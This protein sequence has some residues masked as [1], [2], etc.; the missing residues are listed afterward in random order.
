LNTS[1]YHIYDASAGSGKTFTLVKAYLKILFGSTNLNQFKYILAITFTNKAVAEMKERILDTLKQFENEA[2]LEQPSSMFTML[3][4]ELSLSPEVLHEKSKQTLHQIIHNYAAFDV[5]TIDG[6]THKIIRSFAHDLK[7]PMN[8]EVELDPYALVSE[9]VDLVISKAGIDK[10]LTKTLVDFAIEKADDDKS[11]DIALDFN[12]IGK[13]LLNERDIP[14]IRELLDK[15]PEDFSI[16]KK[17][18]KTDIQATE[19]K[20]VEIAERTINLILE[21]GL[22][23]DD[24]NRSSLP[25][26]FQN[27]SQRKYDI[28]FTSAWQVSLIENQPLYPKRVS[29]DIA[30]II[31]EIQSKLITAFN[32]T[33]ALVSQIKFLKAFYKNTTPLSVLIQ[34]NKALQDIKLDQNKVL[35]SEFNTIIS[36]EIKNQPT[37]FIYERLGEKF[38]HYFIDEFQDTSE[39]QWQ[40]LVPLIDNALSGQNL[41]GQQGTAML[42]GDAKQAIYRWRGGKAEQFIDLINGNTTPFQVAPKVQTLPVN[43]RSFSEIVKFNNTFFKQL[44]ETAFSTE[45]YRNLYLEGAYQETSL[46]QSGYVNLSFLDINKEDDKD[47]LYTHK[48]LETI[49]NCIQNGFRLQDICVLVRRKIEGIAIAAYLSSQ[50]I[51]I[52]S[53]E[54]MLIANSPEVN[55]INNIL[56]LLLQ[57]SNNETKIAV[58]EYLADVH[59]VKNK[60]DFFVAHLSL[61]PFELFKSF[62][63]F[64]VYL[65]HSTV[66]QLPL[67]ELAE[68]IVRAFSLVK[69]SNAYVQFYLDFVLEYSQKKGADLSGF[70]DFF[71]VKKESLSIVSPKNQDAVQIMTIHKAKGL[72]FPVVIFPYADL[73]MTREIDAKEWFPLDKE[74]YH[75]FSSTLLNYSK[76]FEN[77]GETGLD[78]YQRHEAELELDTINLLY[79]ALT[80][81]IEQLHIIGRKDINAKGVINLKTY[82]GLLIQ[83]LTQ[84]GI[85]TDSE[86][87]YAFGNPQRESL[88]LQIEKEPTQQLEFISTAKESHNI[89]IVTNSGLLWDTLQQ[90]A[91]EKGN[92]IHDIMSKIKTESEIDFVIDDYYSMGTINQDQAE[93]LKQKVLE[94]VNH[95]DLKPY[96]AN[97]TISYNERDIISK[98]GSILRPDRL[99]IN[100]NQEAIIIDYKT[101]LHNPKYK[102]QLQDYQDIIEEMN[103]KVIKKILVYINTDLKIEQ[104]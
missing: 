85:F 36:N 86:L 29:E 16:L 19:G 22:E 8:F 60:H 10:K 63:Q 20:V 80:R 70:L 87:S 2:I 72:E 81:P 68:S 9:A 37:P 71:N 23:F 92:L 95:A 64:S 21:C 35:I 40:N 102:E 42:V 18:L 93:I 28:S 13:L 76:D 97:G 56:Q 82:S 54:T 7:L 77:F 53:S 103:Y 98:D 104:Y 27:L 12:K 89:N 75:G 84:N 44:S 57:P 100:Q 65:S 96:Y 30:A 101:G 38:K 34:I 15:N 41:E 73:N 43:Y 31:N 11:W 3:C 67:Y 5:S 62:E 66:L 94:I 52:M 25:K 91:I 47:K 4:E 17:Q 79:V 69:I 59:N 88:L 26:H 24:F 55:F 32:D 74:K 33:K 6:F 90:E 14:F 50:H 78:I 45:M 83:Y 1:N 61:S 51:K 48:V 58:L 46:K 39:L 99:V 49:R